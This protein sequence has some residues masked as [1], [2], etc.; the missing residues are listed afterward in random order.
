MMKNLY[1][2]KITELLALIDKTQDKAISKAADILA[3]A[4]K[5]D[6]IIYTFGAGHSHSVAVEN[7]HRSGCPACVSAILDPSLAF[8]PSAHAATDMERLE[9]LSPIMLKRHNLRKKDCIIIISNSGRNPAGIDAALFAKEKGLKV[10]VITAVQAHKNTKSRHSSGKM[11]R[12]LAD[13]LIDNCCTKQ[14]TALKLNG[15]DIAPV[16]TIAGAAIINAVMYQAARKLAKKG[17]KIPLYLSSNDGGDK[18]NTK[19]AEKYKNRI[20]HLN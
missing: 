16:S 18:V 2:S 15:K 12:D 9:G 1:F 20:L 4:I 3:A 17:F 5:N 19:L 6:G 7:F 14:E 10:I 13:A 11:L 8:M